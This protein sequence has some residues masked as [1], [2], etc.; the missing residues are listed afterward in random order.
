VQAYRKLAQEWHPD[1]FESEADKAT[2]EK[3]FMDIASAKEVLTDPE[4]RQMFDNGTI[5]FL[6]SLLYG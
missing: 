4:K 6:L 2:A 1:K 3:K 5:V